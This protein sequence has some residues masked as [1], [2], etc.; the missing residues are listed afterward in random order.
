M[1]PRGRWPAST[2]LGLAG[3]FSAE[4]V[5]YDVRLDGGFLRLPIWGT[6]SRTRVSPS[7]NLVAWTVFR[8]KATRT[9]PTAA[10]TTTAGIYNLRTG[11]HHGSLEDYTSY[12]DGEKR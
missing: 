6:P 3:A 2:S 9:W 4:L 10:F 8:A 11:E 12:V 5:V 1:P 7:G